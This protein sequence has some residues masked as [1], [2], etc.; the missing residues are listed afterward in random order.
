MQP[1]KQ[2]RGTFELFRSHFDQLLNPN[3]ELIKL[4][5]AID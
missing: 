5:R 4:A 3:H 2:E 1:K